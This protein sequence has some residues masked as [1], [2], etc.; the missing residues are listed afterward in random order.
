MWEESS[1][2]SLRKGNKIKQNVDHE[3]ITDIN[4]NWDKKIELEI[5]YTSLYIFCTSVK[6]TF[7]Y[8]LEI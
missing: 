6:K 3:E 2:H 7:R 4:L 8:L 1:W 5:I